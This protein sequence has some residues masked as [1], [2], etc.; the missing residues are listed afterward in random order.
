MKNKNR[1]NRTKVVVG[2]S[3]GVDSSMTL[4]LLKQMGFEPIGVSLKYCIWENK[5]NLLKENICCTLQSFEIAK[6][7]CQSLN[8]PYYIVDVSQQFK[9][10]IITYFINEYKHNFTP[11]PCVICNQKIKIDALIN[12]ARSHGIYYVATGH[13]G[14]IKRNRTNKEV[15]LCRA[16]DTTKDQTYFLSKLS[17][18]QLRHLILP[19]GNMLKKDVYEF[20]RQNN[21]TN[22]ANTKQSQDFCF[23][24][25]KSLPDFLS[26]FIGQTPGNIV[27]KYGNILGY[28]RG[29]HFFTI[30]Q[31]KGINLGQG[32]YYVKGFDIKHNN[33]IVSKNIQDLQST[34]I[35]LQPYHLINTQFASKKYIKI[36][37]KVRYQDK[38]TDG[39]FKPLSKSR[40]I[41]KLTQPKIAVSPGQFAV[42]YKN[43]ICVGCGRIYQVE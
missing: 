37:V 18:T 1:E 3:G 30:G 32:P 10:K 21:W 33:L 25:N 12:F 20:A 23:V 24:A 31:R 16:K 35:M 42:F 41:I 27:D 22:F 38:L 39:I 34:S 8:V 4:I 26:I 29:L 43:N 2:M 5:K 36:K 11:N 13:Y 7:I 9:K 14:I 15:Y 6:A 40:A 17:Q 28:H 19:L